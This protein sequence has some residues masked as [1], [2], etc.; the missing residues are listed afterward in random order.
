MPGRPVP[1]F[2]FALIF[3]ADALAAPM[4]QHD[5]AS[6]WFEAG[7]VVMADEIAHGTEGADWN[8][9]TTYR[10]TRSWK[11]TLAVGAE[12]EVFDDAYDLTIDPTWDVSDPENP[13][14]VPG[15]E[16]EP[17]A[18]LFLVPSAPR[19]IA[20]GQFT[21]AGLW[22][23][24]P[25]GMRILA[26][27][28]VYRFVQQSNPG[29]YEPFPQGDDPGD[30]LDGALE[31]VE[32]LDLAAFERELADAQARAERAT[33]ALAMTDPAARSAALLALLPPART[34]PP[35]ERPWP[36]GFPADDLSRQLREELAKRG[37][38][39][40]FLEAMGRDVV[41]S[42]RTW[43]GRTFLDPGRTD[44]AGLLLDAAGEPSRPRH[45][46]D[47]ALRV[48][49]DDVPWPLEGEEGEPL[50]ERLAP[51]LADAD[52]WVRAAAVEATAAWLGG[53]AKWKWRAAELLE[54]ALEAE[55][56]ADVLNTYAWSLMARG[57]KEQILDSHLRGERRVVLAA[58]PG[59][60]DPASGTELVLGY[61]FTC[62]DTQ[63]APYHL[64]FVAVA[65]GDDGTVV[66]SSSA[67]ALSASSTTGAGRGI[68]RFRF[69]APLT[70]GTWQVSLEAQLSAR[71]QGP[72]VASTMSAPLALIVP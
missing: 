72:A 3:P 1:L 43:D 33:T 62:R 18:I 27:G 2:A 36:A 26:D 10:V 65:A 53:D 61:E 45:Q 59:P 55:T 21:R 51:L 20:E 68:H 41:G 52:P 7:E 44:R 70:A 69:D 58:R 28:K 56:D 19:M 31:P 30:V 14:Q 35:R 32:P 34:F 22:Q 29:A 50:L 11:G 71:Y 15:P 39:G 60:S 24:V 54:T 12:L 23:K 16:R 8:E 57:M 48:L 38:V 42:F 9:I 47:A 13:R 40:T 6:L 4:E 5:L 46:R 67:E 66:R 49:A 37:D 17:R 64:T 63:P 25:S